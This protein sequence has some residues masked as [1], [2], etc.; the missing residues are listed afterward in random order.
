M[1]PNSDNSQMGLQAGG[2]SDATFALQGA[3]RD[4]QH[5]TVVVWCRVPQKADQGMEFENTVIIVGVILM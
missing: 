3:V 4:L 2:I 1:V 5:P